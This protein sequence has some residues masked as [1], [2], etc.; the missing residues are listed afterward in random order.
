M[1]VVEIKLKALDPNYELTVQSSRLEAHIG[2]TLWL[3]A[4]KLLWN[5]KFANAYEVHTFC[6]Q[7]KSNRYMTIACIRLGFKQHDGT[8]FET[9]V[10]HIYKKD[11]FDGVVEFA[12][13][14]FAVVDVASLYKKKHTVQMV[15]N[16]VLPENI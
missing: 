7:I 15:M 13:V 5:H 9:L 10:Y 4:I 16:P 8:Y 1:Q 6:N 14:V 3:A 2:D 12:K 11:G